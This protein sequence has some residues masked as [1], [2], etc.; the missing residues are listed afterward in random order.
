LIISKNMFGDRTFFGDNWPDRAHKWLACIDHP[1]DKATVDF[2]V[3]VPDHYKVIANGNLINEADEG[4]NYRLYHWRSDEPLP[5]K[6]MVI[7]VAEFGIDTIENNLGIPISTWSYK[8]DTSLWFQPFSKVAEPISFYETILGPYPFSKLADVQSTTIF[9]GMENAGN[10]FYRED[11]MNHRRNPEGTI[12]HEIAHQWFGNSVTEANWYDLWISEGYATYL[13]DLFYEHKYGREV[14]KSRMAE[15]RKMVIRY[16]GRNRAPIIDTTVTDYS[17]LLT[18]NVYEK[19]AWFLHMLR[20]EIGDELFLKCLKTFYEK[21]RYSNAVTGD[22]QDLVE[23]ISG[24]NLNQFFEQWLRKP[25]YPDLNIVWYQK[26]NK[27]LVKIEQ[28]QKDPVFDFPLEL[29][30][31]RTDSTMNTET[32]HVDRTTE[33]FSLPAQG[34][35]INLVPDPEVWLLF[36][37]KAIRKKF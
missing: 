23:S 18:P 24:K 7:G 15:E 9:G 14:F 4:N 28:L 21:Y 32:V 30:I 6:V 22:F 11:L 1:S 16:A 5:T 36:E 17:D 12:A 31:I 2:T 33:T 27:V 35:I 10:I 37:G 26:K 13:T 3:S 8:E 29:G 19:A 34:K 25:G 20:K